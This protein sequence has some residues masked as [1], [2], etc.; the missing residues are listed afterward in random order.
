MTTRRSFMAM[1]AGVL[2]LGGSHAFGQPLPAS[3]PLRKM[4]VINTLG[5]ISDPNIAPGSVP[6][7]MNERAI[8]DVKAAGVTAANITLGGVGGRD[9]PPTFDQGASSI[10]LW[11]KL[12]AQH[13]K[14]LLKVLTTADIRGAKAENKVGLIY[15]FQNAAM[16]EG[17]A[18]NVDVFADLGLRILQLTYNV[19]NQLGGGSLDP[20]NTGLTIFGREVMER[21]GARRLIVDLSHSGQRICLDAARAASRPVCITHTGCAALNPNPRNKTDEELRLV[22]EKGGYVGIYFMPFLVSGRRITGDDVVDHIEHALKVCGEDHVGIGTD[23]TVSAIDDVEAYTV[24]F[25]WDVA[26]RRAAGISAPGEDPNILRFAADLNGPR[27][28]QVIADKLNRRRH[29]W[30]KI[31]K[32]MGRNFLNYAAG[33]WGG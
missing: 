3:S 13:D 18:A 21:A 7:G 25:R 6:E 14:D 5:G 15:G 23:N 33:I 22:A 19:K 9:S 8:A 29:G 11:D 16:V 32:I 31:E 10:A 4:I 28:F 26:Q 17:N 2:A 1:S 12:I 27:Q 20:D 24:E 30:D